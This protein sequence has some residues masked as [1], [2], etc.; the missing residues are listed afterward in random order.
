MRVLVGGDTRKCYYRN[1]RTTFKGDPEH[2][3]LAN[4]LFPWV[5]EAESTLPDGE[6][7]TARA[8][9]NLLK[10]LR[11]VILQDTA[12]LMGIHNRHRFIFQNRR[13]DF[14]STLSTDFQA[15][16]LAHIK[17]RNFLKDESIKNCLPGV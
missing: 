5:E 17:T 9:L 10:N 2:L 15:K 3:E 16:F 7:P 8:F 11:W 14:E 6:N 13:D 4:K 12:V 1:A